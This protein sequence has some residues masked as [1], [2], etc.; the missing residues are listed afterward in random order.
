MKDLIMK[1]IFGGVWN[2]L[3]YKRAREILKT[4]CAVGLLVETTDKEDKRLRRY[5]P[6]ECG[7][8]TNVKEKESPHSAG[9]NISLDN[10]VKVERSFPSM[11]KTCGVCGYERETDIHANTNK[12]DTIPLCEYCLREYWE[13]RNEG[14]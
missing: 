11:L 12:G 6:L 4:L 1:S 13:K 10:I 2:L 3:L 9:E 8:N 7:V 5:I 14:S